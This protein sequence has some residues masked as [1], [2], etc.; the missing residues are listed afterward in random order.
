[1]A[2]WRCSPHLSVLRFSSSH[3][4]LFPTPFMISF[5]VFLAQYPGLVFGSCAHLARLLLI[6]YLCPQEI[7]LRR[8]AILRNNH[9]PWC[10]GRPIIIRLICLYCDP[11]PGVVFRCCTTD[12]SILLMPAVTYIT[13][14]PPQINGMLRW[15]FMS[16]SFPHF[17]RLQFL[18]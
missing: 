11:Q 8:P 14:V 4:P 7:C 9:S 15:W 1:M 5:A 18:H 10:N 6:P 2:P 16:Q 12:I 3:N 13:E 17:F